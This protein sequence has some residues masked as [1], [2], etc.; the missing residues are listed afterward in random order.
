VRRSNGQIVVKKRDYVSL[1]EKHPLFKLPVL[2]GA[3]GLVEMMFIGIETLNFSTEVALRDLTPKDRLNGNG[4]KPGRTT[5]STLRIALTVM[6]SL[7]LG[8][9]IF[10]VVP[11]IA[12]TK[13]F[14]VEQN[15][16]GFNLISGG[17]RIAILLAYL[18]AL[19]LMKDVRRLFQ[20]HGAEHKA[21]FTFESMADLTTESASRFTRFHPRCGTSFILI[22]MIA[23]MLFFSVVD[24]LLILWLGK[25]SL[26][27]RML[28]HIPLIPLVGGIAYEFIR[29]SARRSNTPV[30][31]VLVAPGLWLQGIT[32][33]E[34]DPSQI[35]VALVALTCAL[36]VDNPEGAVS[37]HHPSE[38][39]LN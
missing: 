11:L 30:G 38:L 15:A 36:G 20:Y 12:A 13:L 19:T 7:T 9:A 6:L 8:I 16:L 4:A 32:T 24:S 27:I 3:V 23:S 2:R 35:E 18:L 14:N 17:I 25:I 34:P 37:V 22:V 33:R 26:P 1:A 39:A 29:W 31:R 10:F 28:T 21:V 5:A